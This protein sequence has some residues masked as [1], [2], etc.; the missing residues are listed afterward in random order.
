MGLL[1]YFFSERKSLT[2]KLKNNQINRYK[3]RVLN[4][5]KKG[6]NLK[7]HLV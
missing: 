2:D 4:K 3:F 6:M 7:D 5:L 1:F